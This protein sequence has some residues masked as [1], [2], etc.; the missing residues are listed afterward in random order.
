MAARGYEFYLSHSFASLTRERYFQHS[1]IKFVS[2]RGHVI[3]SI[4]DTT[5]L[6]LLTIVAPSGLGVEKIIVTRQTPKTHGQYHRVLQ[7]TTG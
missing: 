5:I 6:H 4:Y 3:S 1:K 7:S 2:P